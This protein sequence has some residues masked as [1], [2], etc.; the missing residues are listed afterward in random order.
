MTTR[1][2]SC[3]PG[4]QVCSKRHG[5]RRHRTVNEAPQPL[6]TLADVSCVRV[7]RDS[8]PA[9]SGRHLCHTSINNTPWQFDRSL[10]RAHWMHCCWPVPSLAGA[11]GPVCSTPHNSGTQ[12]PLLVRSAISRIRL[13]YCIVEPEVQVSRAKPSSL[14]H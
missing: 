8:E 5:T 13:T 10:Q 11:T 3:N 2:K 9:I 14:R 7:P 1:S 12:A 4:I 6:T